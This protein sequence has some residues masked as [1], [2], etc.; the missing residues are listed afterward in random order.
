MPLKAILF[1]LD[2]TLFDHRHSS[3]CGL[4]V[5]YAQYPCFQQ[6][7]FDEFER[8][9]HDILEA[10]HLKLLEGHLTLDESR[11]QRFLHLFALYGEPA[12][13][14]LA[15]QVAALYREAYLAAEKLV[16]GVVPLLER[17]RAQGLKIAIVTN[18]TAP[19]QRRKLKGLQIEHLIDVLVI[20]EEVGIAK[21]APRIFEVALER[22]GCDASEVV[23]V[24]DSWSADI[25]GAAAA[26]IRAVWINR[27]GV[28]CPDTALATELPALEPLEDTL[29]CLLGESLTQ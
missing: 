24:G 7:S 15:A 17:L 29:R 5:V 8:S 6:K 4:E 1:D 12:D 25:M 2:D 18:S 9:H 10:L 23:M 14:A 21:P 16:G 11:K 27:Y 28:A 22:L 13:D 20:S 26:G 19:E 3:R